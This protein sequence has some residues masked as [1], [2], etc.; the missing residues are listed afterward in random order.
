MIQTCGLI[1]S[2]FICS[3]L[4][5]DNFKQKISGLQKHPSS[6]PDLIDNKKSSKRVVEA[7]CEKAL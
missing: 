4:S 3:P 6:E 1:P 2:N 7:T 5:G